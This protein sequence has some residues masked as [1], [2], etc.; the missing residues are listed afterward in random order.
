[1]ATRPT[2]SDA[3][4]DESL[5]RALLGCAVYWS[6]GNS[7]APAVDEI[8]H[9]I[10]FHGL[11]VA[12]AE[13]A[14]SLKWPDE[15]THEI[16][17]VA[18]YQVMADLAARALLVPIT[19]DLACQKVQLVFLKGTAMA[20]SVYDQPAARQRGDI[21]VLVAQRDLHRVR[22]CL[23]KAG[24]ERSSASQ[25]RFGSQNPQETWQ[26]RGPG[27]LNCT[28]DLHWAIFNA[29]ALTDVIPTDAA[30]EN[31]VPLPRLSVSAFAL[32]PVDRLIHACCNQKSHA[33]G[34]VYLDE[35]RICEP[36]RLGWLMDID[37]QARQF[38]ASQW[39]QLMERVERGSVADICHEFLEHSAQK[40]GTPIPGFVLKRLS[41]ATKQTPARY[42]EQS[43][44]KQRFVHDWKAQPDLSQKLQL[45]LSRA[46]PTRDILLKRYPDHQSW[47][48]FFLNLRRLRDILFNAN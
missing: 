41:M 30:I 15:I 17:K 31:A 33:H 6:G 35:D 19:E 3:F 20:Y 47:P 38:S 34:G 10:R 16:Q 2:R 23:E 14:V 21:D 46:F 18:R 37:L 44:A 5:R 11:A 45:L 22:D 7:Q 42:L 29:P 8:I 32:Q 43:D 26:A 1:M 40:L 13:K 36:Y 39:S 27:G 24:L 9:R 4:I 28:I 25:G 12:L 48:T